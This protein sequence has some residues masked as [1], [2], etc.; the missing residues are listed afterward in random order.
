MCYDIM[1]NLSYI[2]VLLLRSLMLGGIVYYTTSTIPSKAIT[3]HNKMIIAVIVVVLYALLDYFSSFFKG[4][5]GLL[6]RAACGCSPYESY[7]L[8]LSTPGLGSPSTSV[9]NGALGVSAELDEAIRQ[10]KASTKGNTLAPEESDTESVTEATIK[11][12]AECEAAKGPA[13]KEAISEGFSL[14]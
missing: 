11:N 9:S 4:I 14:F 13:P 2:A 8:S 12:A 6:C 10:L 7:D 1:L 5:R 3:T